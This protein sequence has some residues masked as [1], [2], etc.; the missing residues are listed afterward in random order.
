MVSVCFYSFGWFVLCFEFITVVIHILLKPSTGMTMGTFRPRTPAI[1]PRPDA[2]Y[3]ALTDLR[4]PF[5]LLSTRF[6]EV[7]Y[8]FLCSA[9]S[10]AEIII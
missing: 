5:A 7:C 9:D 10:A 8:F 6:L 4:P 1:V 2:V 3:D